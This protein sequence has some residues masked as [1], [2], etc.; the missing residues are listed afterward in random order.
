MH[1]FNTWTF[2]RENWMRWSKLVN[3]RNLNLTKFFIHSHSKHCR[4]WERRNAKRKK[5]KWWQW[6]AFS[7]GILTLD[8]TRYILY[9]ALLCCAVLCFALLCFALHCFALLC[10]ALLCFALLCSSLLCFALLCF[11]LLYLT[12]LGVEWVYNRTS[13]IHPVVY[14]GIPR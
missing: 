6:I 7:M 3:R 4:K 14:I 11:A 12:L 2:L 1:W 13:V 9:F 8:C 5:V 10:F